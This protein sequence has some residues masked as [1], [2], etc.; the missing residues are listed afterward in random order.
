ME[1]NPVRA[2]Q[3]VSAYLDHLAVEKNASPHT[4]SN[5]RRDLNKYVSWMKLRNL[6][7]DRVDENEVEQ[8]IADLRQ[9][10]PTL[11]WSPLAASSA[12]RAT[13][14]VR[15]LHRFA[16]EEGAL[17]SDVTVGVSVPRP[18]QTLPHALTVEQVA[19]LIDSCP[20][21]E[22]HNPI[23][24][25][26]RALVEL[27]YGTGVRISEALS[28]D[29]DSIDRGHSFVRVMGKGRKERLVPI[30]APALHAIDAWLVQGRPSMVKKSDKALFLN[31]RGNRLGRQSAWKFLH[32]AAERCGL[33]D[34]VGPHTLRHSYATHLLQGGA[35]IRVVQELLGHASVTTTQIYTAVSIENLREVYATS[36]PRA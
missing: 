30:G 4:L 13:V 35:D 26:D 16:H 19:R 6:T 21:P 20:I 17:V 18:A 9:G 2:D 23:A 24:L 10:D 3:L 22:S 7:I 25:R 12:A 14:T 34:A 31:N 29:I 36:H 8:F 32:S 28:L 1:H 5:Y 15:S 11:G 33:G 27:L